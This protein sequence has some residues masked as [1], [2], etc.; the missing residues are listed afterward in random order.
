MK[1]YIKRSAV[2]GA[3][4]LAIG[5]CH[6]LVGGITSGILLIVNGGKLEA[7]IKH[8]VLTRFGKNNFQSRNIPAKHPKAENASFET[9]EQLKAALSAANRSAILLLQFQKALIELFKI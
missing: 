4:N 9:R 7:K 8:Y 1:S 6:V 2:W 5:I 3:A